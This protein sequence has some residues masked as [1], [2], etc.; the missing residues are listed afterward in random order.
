MRSYRLDL[1]VIISVVG[2]FTL[3]VFCMI[4]FVFDLATNEQIFSVLRSYAHIILPT[5]LFW[6]LTS[7]Y[8]WHTRLFQAIRKSANIPPDVRGRWEGTLINAEDG[9]T[10]KFAIEVKQTLTTLTVFSYSSLGR[11]VSLLPEIASSH[12]EDVF[13]L[14]YLWQGETHT[15]RKDVHLRVRFNGYTILTLHE[16]ENPRALRGF[17]FTNHKPRQTR[18]S[19][20]LT[21]VSKELKKRLE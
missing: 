8:L 5:S 9:Q 19:I 16:H 21:W 2:I 13:S 4:F 17:Y 6:I 11:S 10:Q 20:E 7:R 15:S 1:G 3:F 18:G 12:N 14:C